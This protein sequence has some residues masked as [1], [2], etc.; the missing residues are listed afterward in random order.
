MTLGT[1]V[2]GS[3]DMPT[4]VE[5]SVYNQPERDQIALR[6]GCARCTRNEDDKLNENSTS[7]MAE[8]VG[9]EPLIAEPCDALCGLI[10]ALETKHL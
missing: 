2:R 7:R 10:Q 4:K 5:L 3:N 6:Q 9:F 1:R 8:R